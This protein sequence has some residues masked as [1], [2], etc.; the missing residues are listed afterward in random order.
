V[1]RRRK[2]RRRAGL[3]RAG[4]GNPVQAV[5]HSLQEQAALLGGEPRKRLGVGLLEASALRAAKQDETE[6]QS[7]YAAVMSLRYHGEA[8][9]AEHPRF[10]NCLHREERRSTVLVRA[11]R[12][13]V[14]SMKLSM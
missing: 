7:L 1:A 11:E 10:R 13:F 2:S 14:V 8:I 5:G 6:T 9:T 12:S 3:A 4:L